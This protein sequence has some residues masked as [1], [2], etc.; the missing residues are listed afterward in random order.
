MGYGDF[1]CT[2]IREPDAFRVFFKKNNYYFYLVLHYFSGIR[3]GCV[4]LLNTVRLRVRPKYHVY[5]HIHEGYGVRSD[6]KVIFIN[7][8]ICDINYMPTNRPV[9][10]DITMPKGHSKD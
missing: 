4:E 5:G 8:S 2:G 10:F 1:C 3:A 6:G 9:V 7:A